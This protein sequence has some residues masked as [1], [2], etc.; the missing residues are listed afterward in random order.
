MMD[1]ASIQLILQ[2]LI[3]VNTITPPGKN[4]K[5]IANIVKEQLLP[6]GC[7]IKII[8]TPEKRVR[9]LHQETDGILGERV[10]LVAT[11]TRGEGKSI[12][13]NAHVDVVPVG[14]GWTYP[15]F[16][17]SKKDEKYFG[18]GVA[19]DK[20]TLAMLI[21]VFKELARD[22]N[23]KGSIVL[24]ATVDEEIG[25]YTGLAY[26]LDQCIVTA[27]YCI[28]GDGSI[29]YITNA[30]N[31][32]LRIRIIVHGKSVHSSMNW[33]GVNA[34]EKAARLITRLE[35]YNKALHTRK[36]KIPANPRS[37]VEWL[38]PSL[39]A[40][41]INGGIKVNIIP[42]RC[43]IEID[44]RVLPDE[45]KSAAVEEVKA[46]LDELA[47]DDEEFHYDFFA[48]GFHDS[49]QTPETHELVTAMQ[50]AFK[51]VLKKKVNVFGGLGCLD[52]SYVAKHKIPVVNF[53]VSRI[54][55]R[56]HG[57]DECVYI[58]DLQDFG[59]IIKE[60]ILSLL[61]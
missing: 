36:S 59:L 51:K 23:W 7:D 14:T 28:V 11:L 38:T 44:R 43:I 30:S 53:G 15:P 16:T 32:C 39:T 42:D 33:M 12:M 37:G 55:S 13:L 60:T 18:R 6:T 49:W 61:Q 24:T 56:V 22:P 9:E 35:K 58:K 4:Y 29:E 57:V 34:I 8:K 19:D 2:P 50:S 17:L 40:G 26:L 25:D 45:D 48:G 31:G 47:I 21:L 3:E 46:I 5:K 27:D 10:N 1:E 20:G 41:M 52:A 54:E